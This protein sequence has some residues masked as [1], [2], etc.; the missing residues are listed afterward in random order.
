[1]QAM[2]D[3]SVD[4]VEDELL[5]SLGAAKG[6]RRLVSL[7]QRTAV[8]ERL[9]GREYAVAAGGSLSNTL[10]A[11]ARLGQAGA[12][13]RGE[14]PLRVGMAGLVGDDPLGEFY[15]AQMRGAG[16][17]LASPPRAGAATGTVTV[18]TSPD[19]QRTMLSYPG[20]AVEVEVDAGL[21]AAIAASR[22]LVLEG[23][24]WE[25]PG[26]A[27]TVA[28]VRTWAAQGHA[29]WGHVERRGATGHRRHRCHRGHHCAVVTPVTSQLQVLTSTPP[30]SCRPLPLPE[31]AAAWWP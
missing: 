2:V 1:M 6:S 19:A 10:V 4:Q 28:K 18:L 23:Y 15:A 14:P 8:L 26:A 5:E 22:L 7:E 21:G 3:L 30:P 25:L 16:V 11:L 12:A 13:A 20:S 17:D 9:R 24:L 27:A 29:G 31:Q